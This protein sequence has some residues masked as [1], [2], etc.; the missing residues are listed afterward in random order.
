VNAEGYS[1]SPTSLPD[2]LASR[3][4]APKRG[5]A[6]VRELGGG[7]SNIVLLV[8]WPEAGPERRWV[9]KQSLEKLRVKDE[10][11]SDRERVFREAD[12][13]QALRPALGDSALPEVIQVDRENFLFVM[14]AAPSGSVVWKDALLK[15]SVEIEVARRAGE[16][17]ARL[18]NAS[19]QD[20]Q[21]SE[22]FQDRRVFDQ[23]R[24]DPYYRT[25][26]ARHPDVA[27]ALQALIESSWK[28][29]TGLVHGDYSPKN[30][31][32]RD[33]N[34]F[35]IDFEVV[36]WG[37]PSFDAGFLLNHLFLKALYQPR[38]ASSYFEAVREFWR[39]LVTQLENEPGR[40]FEA[41]TVRH[42]GG[43]M[44]ARIDGKSS[45]EYICEESIK[46]GVRSVAKHLLHEQPRRLE[47][48]IELV[49]AKCEEQSMKH[50]GGTMN[51]E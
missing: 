23:L 1:L 47:E 32:V 35:L 44:L 46:N 6:S 4:L 9:V 16:L 5:K 20:A 19:R 21:F 26:A 10:W 13:L 28:V 12:A 36:H 39:S 11:R 17:L 40:E 51:A 48:V 49:R 22:R 34:I 42:L 18:I 15:G 33:G 41:L 27:P 24:V 7:V 2:Y 31:L 37:D 25:A 3:G 30:M 45:V 38:F 50:E 43:L 29:R 8:E 14:S